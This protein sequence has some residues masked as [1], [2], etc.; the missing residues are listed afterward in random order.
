MNRVSTR[1]T[2]WREVG[3]ELSISTPQ[4]NAI[5]YE[6]RTVQQC[7]EHVF[8]LWKSST[9]MPY[10]WDTLITALKAPQVNEQRLASEIEQSLT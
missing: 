1:T 6:V 7:F 8:E 9:S 3:I 4:L 5:S 10:T 2:K